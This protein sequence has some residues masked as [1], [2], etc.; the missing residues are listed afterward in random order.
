MLMLMTAVGASEILDIFTNRG[1]CGGE[2]G[3]RDNEIE[4][5]ARGPLIMWLTRP[6]E[7]PPGCRECPG[8]DAPPLLLGTASRT[9]HCLLVSNVFFGFYVRLAGDFIQKKPFLRYGWKSVVNASP[10]PTFL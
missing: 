4:T 1:R 5:L 7:I 2:C 9:G 3:G 6:L 10:R 8:R